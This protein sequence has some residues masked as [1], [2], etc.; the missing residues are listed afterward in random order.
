MIID[1]DA[2]PIAA[3]VREWCA[4]GGGDPAQLALAGGDDYEL[5]FTVRPRLR[6]RLK[7]ASRHSDVPI[8]RIGVCTNES[9]L[10]LRKSLNGVI[11]NTPVPG[12]Y[13]HFAS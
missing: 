10:V 13:T 8:V 12:G 1:A 2:L 5:L 6:G 3:C 11:Q 9:S 4:A 7:A